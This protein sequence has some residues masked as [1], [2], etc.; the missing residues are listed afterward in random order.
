MTLSITLSPKVLINGLMITAIF[1]R[2]NRWLYRYYH[3]RRFVMK[4]ENYDIQ[5]F[6]FIFFYASTRF[7]QWYLSFLYIPF[8][9][10]A[11]IPHKTLQCIPDSIVTI[12]HVL[13]CVL[14]G[15]FLLNT[16]LFLTSDVCSCN[17]RGR[18]SYVCNRNHRLQI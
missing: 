4:A 7:P 9:L 1:H 14:C 10:F 13:C 3:V 8:R 5:N 6:V 18:F 17:N 16:N 11:L 2:N 15:I 12:L